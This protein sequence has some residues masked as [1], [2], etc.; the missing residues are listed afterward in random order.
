MPNISIN[1]AEAWLSLLC[2]FHVQYGICFVPSADEISIMLKSSE[3]WPGVVTYS[4]E[5][6]DYVVVSDS[7]LVWG[8]KSRGGLLKGR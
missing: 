3:S 6:L 2:R 7:T 1:A 5:V 8:G 4:P